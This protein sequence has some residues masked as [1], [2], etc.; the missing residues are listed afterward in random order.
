MHLIL[1]LI[2]STLAVMVAAYVIPGVSVGGWFAAFVVAIVLGIFNT[3]LKPVLVLLTL[4]LNIITLG[5][6]TL[7]INTALILLAGA[8]VPGFHPGSFFAA[9]LFGL[10]LSVINMFASPLKAVT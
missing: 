8:I 4:P 2:I 1:H 9:F 3:F 10:A 5:L 6:F 7:V